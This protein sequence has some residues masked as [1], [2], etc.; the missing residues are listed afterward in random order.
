MEKYPFY[1]VICKRFNY[2]YVKRRG[3]TTFKILFKDIETRFKHCKG[4]ERYKEI[5]NLLVGIDNQLF[6]AVKAHSNTQIFNKDL[7]PYAMS[8]TSMAIAI[9]SLLIYLQKDEKKIVFIN[10][11]GLLVVLLL[12]YF[13]LRK[14]I[15]LTPKHKYVISI[16][17]D[18]KKGERGAQLKNMYLYYY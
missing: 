4:E 5:R 10:L 16:I 1:V 2:N 18:I 12:V 3:I 8:F 14:V 13:S 6:L 7:L 9:I 17:E 15:A 11:T